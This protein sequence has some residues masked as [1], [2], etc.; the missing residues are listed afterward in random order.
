MDHRSAHAPSRPGTTRRHVTRRRTRG[1]PLI[2]AAVTVLTV[3]PAATA[4]PAVATPLLPSLPGGIPSLPFPGLGAGAPIPGTSEGPGFTLS[5]SEDLRDDSVI[6]VTGA[7]YAAGENIYVTQTI[8]KPESGYPET[9]GEAVKVTVGEDGRFTADLPVDVVFGE[10]DCRSTQC[11]VATFMAFPKLTDRSQDAWEPIH[12][13]DGATAS[14]APAGS[15]APAAAGAAGNSGAGTRP[16]T[17]GTAAPSQSTGRSA[18][19]ATSSNGPAVTLSTT[20]IAA[21]G[22]TSITVTG[23]GFSTSGAG[24][25]VGIAEKAKFSHTDAS[26][27]GSVN[28]VKASDMGADGSFTTIVEAEPVFAAGNCIDNAC[29]L[30]TFAAHGS[31]DRSQDTATDLVV[32]GTTAEKAAASAAAPSATRTG[33]KPVGSTSTPGS[34]SGQPAGLGTGGDAGTDGGPATTD[35]TL[36]AAASPMATLSAGLIGALVGAAILG[37]GMLLGRRTRRTDAAGSV[38]EVF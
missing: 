27:F 23:T 18:G 30:F 31:S 21:S 9:Y 38:E 8:E 28:Y 22:V 12:F 11:Y 20:E 7:G 19:A 26:Q 15:P 10:V 24:V 32:A 36:T 3:L 34:G 1:L 6:T 35:A 13:A 17:T 33:T 37:A 16:A 14:A 5:S 29:A 25:Y 4:A 2:A